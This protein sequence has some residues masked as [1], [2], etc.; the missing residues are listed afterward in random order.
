MKVLYFTRDYT[1]HD[2]RYLSALARTGHQVYYL[3]LEQRGHQLEDRPVPPE[4]HIVPW[5]GGREPA[6]LSN[7]PRLLASLK[8]VI[9]RIQ[10]DLIHAG[11]IQTSALLA[12]LSG[13]RPLVSMSWGYDLLQDAERNTWQRWATS[14]VMRRSD[15]LIADCRPVVE[16]AIAF[17]MPE[18]RIVAYPW[19]VDLEHFK[20]GPG[21]DPWP[22][23]EP[24]DLQPF[25]LLSTRSWEPVY[26]VDLI[27]RAFVRAARQRPELRLIMLGNGSQ[28]GLLRRIF[29]QGQVEDR[30]FFP[31]QV[32]QRDLPRFYRSADL[33]I[34]ASHSDGTSISLLEA[35]AC[36]TP[37]LLSDIPGNRE[38][39][40][41]GAQGWFFPNGDEQALA[42]GMLRAVDERSRLPEVGRQARRLA[43]ERADWEKNFRGLLQAYEI[44]RS[45]PRQN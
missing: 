17:G 31:G 40:E 34:S 16:K 30:V 33:Y 37:V 6:R 41:P 18:E 35:L 10:P 9:A 45:N 22:A 13:F 7:G 21:E 12:A 42:E 25:Y 2:H 4:V 28:A 29:N 38:W 44:A 3:R 36:G 8:E 39:I 20:P 43:E 11:P 15:A 24:P 23:P 14:Y 27:A 19:G 26:G 5:A 1:T 32:G